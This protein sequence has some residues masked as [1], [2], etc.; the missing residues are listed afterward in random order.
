VALSNFDFVKP[1]AGLDVSMSQ[2]RNHEHSGFEVFDYPGPYLERDQGERYARIRIEQL[3]NRHLRVIAQGNVTGAVPGGL[4]TLSEHPLKSANAEYMITAVKHDLTVADYETGR[5]QTTEYKNQL[6]AMTSAEVFRPL[7]SARKVLVSGPQT[8]IVVGPSGEE[9]WTDE[10]GR[11]KVQFHWDRFGRSDENSSCWIRVSQQWAGAQWGA[12]QLPRIGQ[13]VIVDFLEGDPDQPIITGRVYNADNMPPYALPDKK[14][15][16]GIKS[17]STKT[18]TADNYNEIRFDDA[19]GQE[20]L[21]IHAEKD[22]QIVVE[23]AESHQVG[24]NRNKSIGNDEEVSI[25]QNQTVTIG[26]D[27]T[28]TIGQN[29][30][31]SIGA[32]DVTTVGASRSLEVGAAESVN[33]GANAS[34]SVADS[35]T[36]SIGSDFSLTIGG[37]SSDTIGKSSSSSIGESR[38]VNV[39]KSDALSV[40]KKLVIDAGDEITLQTGKAKLIMKKNG[41]ITLQGNKITVKGSSSITVKSSSAVTIKGSKINQN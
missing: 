23:N 11:V 19:K 26:Q 25:G 7:H 8:G 9:I 29:R 38:S 31:A 17:R 12:I 22:Q 30:N 2:I 13:E 4:F 33:I 37:D 1:K 18:G 20:K 3:Q 6:E 32:S 24:S 14:T 21:V 28:D 41:D 16:S 15:Q 5:S 36:I 27:K 34:R 10:Y 40:G 35:Q 39:G